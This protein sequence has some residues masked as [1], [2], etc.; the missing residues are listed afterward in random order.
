MGQAVKRKMG[1]SPS[2]NPGKSCQVIDLIDVLLT[3]ERRK[4]VGHHYVTGGDKR[5][6]EVIRL[7]DS[8]LEQM[9]KRGAIDG[10]GFA[11][12]EKYRRHWER[13]GLLPAVG[14]IDLTGV[15]GSSP[16]NR[17][18]MPKS[19]AQWDHRKKYRTATQE[20]GMIVTATV[21]RVVLHEWT[22]V[23]AGQKLGYKS[24][25]RAREHAYSVLR[26]AGK[27]LADLWGIG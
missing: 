27:K 5:V 25:F 19:E 14:S 20:M 15:F 21:D 18:L 17:D 8:P 24:E 6:G 7:T 4:Q 10:P 23:R 11:A 26:G 12:L 2:G 13:G 16:C 22:A 3:P 9:H 1:T